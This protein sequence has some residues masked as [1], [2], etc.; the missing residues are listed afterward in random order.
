[1]E[2]SIATPGRGRGSTGLPV[3]LRE[4]TPKQ[5]YPGNVVF[6]EAVI[7][8][9]AG[10]EN[11]FQLLSDKSD[12]YKAKKIINDLLAQTIRNKQNGEMNSIFV[13]QKLT[14]PGLQKGFVIYRR[15]CSVCHGADGEGIQYLA[16]PLNGSEYVAGPT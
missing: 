7:S 16:P 12:Y 4:P 10:L 6:Q 2:T 8:S 11:D 3:R 9:L 15:T 5:T 14:V 13:Q 1:M